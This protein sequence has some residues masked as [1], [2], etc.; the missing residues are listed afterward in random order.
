MNRIAILLLLVTACLVVGC[1][2]IQVQQELADQNKAN[3]QQAH[4]DIDIMADLLDRAATG[5]ETWKD[6]WDDPE[7]TDPDLKGAIKES[8]Q[9]NA[10][11]NVQTAE[12]IVEVAKLNE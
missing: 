2:N 8:I 10:D 6:E 12:E 9:K 11:A 4:D 1:S 3:A 5:D 7:E